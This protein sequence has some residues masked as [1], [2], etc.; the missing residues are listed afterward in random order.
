M[1]QI[2]FDANVIFTNW[3]LNGPSMVLIE[4]LIASGECK[5]IVPE[6]VILEAHNL[7]KEEMSKL[8]QE[9]KKFNGLVTNAQHA[10]KVPDIDQICKQYESA[11]DSRLTTLNTYRLPF[12]DIPQ[13]SIVS[14]ALARKIPFHES[15]R[16]FRDALIWECILKVVNSDNVTFFVSKNCK[17]FCNKGSIEQLHPDLLNDLKAKEL[18]ENCVCLCSDIKGLVNSH[19]LSHLEKVVNDAT[20]QL[21]QGQ[22]KQF[23]I[24]QWFIDNREQIE[25][26]L[27]K[28]ADFEAVLYG[29]HELEDPSVSYIENPDDITVE[30]AFALEDDKVYIDAKAYADVIFDVFIFKP[31]YYIMED[32]YP[33]EIQDSDWNEHYVWAQLTIHIPIRFS[34]IFNVLEVRVEEFEVNGFEEIF[35]WC[36]FCG[37]AVLNDASERCYKCGKSFF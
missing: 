18:P 6:I 14:R 27:N 29:Y 36:K 26:L 17:D 37:A 5:L 12:S 15:G 25:T 19:L 4:K 20:K 1:I 31:D 32:E 28:D 8:I 21:K 30:E 23:S 11:L 24:R 2:V 22:Y 9:M 35:G 10:I 33:L 34:M 16:G 7:Y 13:T 3:Q